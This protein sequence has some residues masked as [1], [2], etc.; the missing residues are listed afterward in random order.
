MTPDIK[1]FKA[2]KKSET[3]LS[4][5]EERNYKRRFL[6]GVRNLPAEKWVSIGEVVFL[7]I[8]FFINFWLFSP[9]FGKE[10]IINAFSAPLIPI[11][12]TLSSLFIPFSYGVRMWLA[13]FLLFFPL[14]FYFF[15]REISQ[16]KLAATLAVLVA[17]LPISIFL[18]ARIKF[19][20][21]LNDGAHLASLTLIAIVC[22]LLLKFL[23]RGSF[24][25][26]ML[27]SFISALVALTS[28][29][30]LV[31]LVCFCLAIVFSEMLL[32]Q[33][34]LKFLRLVTV[35]SLAVG[36]CAF[37][38]NPKYALAILNSSQGGLIK[39]A[40]SNL[41]PISFF[42]IPLLGTFG[43]LLF[44]NRPQFQ[45]LFLAV[46][47]SVGF[48]LLT[49]GTG[50]P[51]SAPSRFIPVFGVSLAFLSGVV[52]TNLLDFLRKLLTIKRFQK[53]AHIRRLIPSFLVSLFASLFLVTIVSGKS[54]RR[55][56]ETR[57]LGFSTIKKVGIWEVRG[58]TGGL[59]N[60]LGAGISFLTT[61]SIIYIGV[62]L[63]KKKAK[64]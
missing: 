54:L 46:F 22:L 5:V 36:F 32:G 26:G 38:Y 42:L 50:V 13:I 3:L 47:L 10:D 12:A 37:W 60:F 11:L 28:P 55:V 52:L 21:L 45:P 24:F 44:E 34:R 4:K 23:R 61:G 59:A 30:G 58:D 14:T 18:P 63:K 1:F 25:I 57:V 62:G 39:L 64:K 56:E 29:L 33:G 2:P 51:L 40:I 53:I 19:G 9:F 43:F 27:C 15:V 48:G 8:L 6:A 41:L 20:L 49:L 7:L 17:T 35:F 16:R 31:V